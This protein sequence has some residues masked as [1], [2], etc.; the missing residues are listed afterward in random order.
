MLQV[1]ILPAD[2]QKL[3]PADSKLH[4]QQNRES[5]RVGQSVGPYLLIL[6]FLICSSLVGLDAAL[7]PQCFGDWI[8][9]AES[10]F[11]AAVKNSFQRSAVLFER[12]ES[13]V[14]LYAAKEN[15]NVDGENGIDVLVAKIWN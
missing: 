15:L 13:V 2:A 9:F 1:N 4:Q 11:H 7:N 12:F 5:Q 3:T 8:A 10:V 14:I 6:I